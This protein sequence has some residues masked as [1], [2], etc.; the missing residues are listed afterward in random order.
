MRIRWPW[1][2]KTRRHDAHERAKAADQLTREQAEEAKRRLAES[3]RLAARFRAL[4]EKNHFAEG[5][6]NALGEGR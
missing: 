5:I 1:Q 3:Q 2:R 4:R 6:R